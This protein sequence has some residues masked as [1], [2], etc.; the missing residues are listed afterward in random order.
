M[1][2]KEYPRLLERCV[3]ERLENGLLICVVPKAGFSR[4]YAFLATDYGS[5][6]TKFLLDGEVRTS[7]DGVAHY[8][9]HKMFD[10]PEGD[11][12]YAFAKLGASPNAFTSYAMTAYHFDCTAHFEEN[13]RI[14]L[15]FV[16]TP[17][18]TQESVE[19]ERGIIEQEIRMYLDSAGSRVYENLFAA[20]YHQHPVR[21]PIAG[22]VES[23]G[24]IDAGTLEACYRAFYAPSNMMLCVVG[25]VEP[26]RVF[27]IAREV[28]KQDGGSKA[29]HD[30]GGEEPMAPAR[31]R[32]VERMEIAMPTFAMGIKCSPCS[33]EENI[34]H[35]EAVGDFAAELL[36]GESTELYR[37]LYERGLIDSDFSIGFECMR[38]MAVI[39]AS[40]DSM[41]P[42]RVQEEILLAAE[43]LLR[44]GIDEAQ[45]QRL[46]K[47]AIGRRIRDLDSF[48]SICY[49]LCAYR[50][51]GVDY[52]TFPEVYASLRSEEVLRFLRENLRRER[53]AMS[54][55]YPKAEG[56]EAEDA[57]PD[58]QETEFEV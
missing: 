34:M 16:S 48:E 33:E 17:Y 43:R 25:D 11:A 47:A 57:A 19:K 22:T 45:F 31:S 50:F 41:E 20:L 58:K 55:I 36:A 32:I 23:I 13:L 15:R 30:Y 39:V 26:E 44:D 37:S 6:D 27:A 18:F 10:M 2:Q 40:G 1:T 7:P 51:D 24:E 9:E 8:L 29:L 56:D 42:E 46:K 12:T 35:F 49:R 21:V 5:N 38:G 14:L 54:L 53:C 52:F 28:M 3:E 4:A